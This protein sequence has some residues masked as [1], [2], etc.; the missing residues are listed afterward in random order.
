MPTQPDQAPRGGGAVNY[1]GPVRIA[2][3]PQSD[4]R[5]D[6]GEVV[7]AWVSYD[8]DPSIG[9]DR[10]VVL[11]GWTRDR[12][13]AALMLSS[14]DHGGQRG[15]L[16]LGRGP[17]DREGRSSWVRLDRLLA[18]SPSAVR[19]EGAVLPRSAFN[20]VIDALA[21]DPSMARYLVRPRPTLLTRLRRWFGSSARESATGRRDRP[22]RS[23]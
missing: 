18:I 12:R 13:L 1:A 16:R 22:G 20:A 8:E 4:G 6:A 17:W 21:A 23:R 2:Y 5:A 11:I 9:K 3:Q 7:W 15:W 14:R 19:R 10:P